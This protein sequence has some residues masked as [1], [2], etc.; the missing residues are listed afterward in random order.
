MNNEILQKIK[1]LQ[2]Y[3]KE[4]EEMHKNEEQIKKESLSAFIISASS[5]LNDIADAIENEK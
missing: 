3:L 5:Y 4:F 1:G 2:E